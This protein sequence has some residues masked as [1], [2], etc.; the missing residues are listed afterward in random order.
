MNDRAMNDWAMN[1]R[2]LLYFVLLLATATTTMAASQQECACDGPPLPEI[3]A[4]VNGVHIV[5]N[6]I[7]EPIRGELE[8]LRQQVIEARDRELGLQINSMLADAEAK[9]RGIS[10]TKLLQD[11]VVSKVKEPAD[12]D[13]KLF[14][15]QNRGKLSGEFKDLKDSILRHLKEQRQNDEAKKFSDRLREAAGV[16]VLAREVTP[17]A[18]DAELSRVFA[19]IGEKQTVTSGDVERGL[20]PLLTQVR[21]QIYTLRRNELDSR[22]AEVLLQQEALARKIT[23]RALLDQ[24]VTPKIQPVTD[25]GL[26]EFYDKNKDRIN[27]TFTEVKNQMTEFLAKGERQKAETAYVEQLKAKAA[28]DEHLVQPPAAA[29]IPDKAGASTTKSR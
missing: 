29:S 2:V 27:G 4:V 19:T 11:E 12:D 10:A 15:E 24:D 28:I 23:I 13:A 17:P 22:I 9:R 14:F 21:D 6:D 20:A 3:V 18:N 26:H 25:A 1:C 5:P 7:D 16:K 8:R